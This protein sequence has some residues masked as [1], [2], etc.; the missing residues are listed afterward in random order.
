MRLH[1]FSTLVT[2]SCIMAGLAAP[3]TLATPIE[4]LV[5][6]NTTSINTQNGYIDMQFNPSA[7][8]GGGITTATATVT[9]FVTNGTYNPNPSDT[10]SGTQGNVTV[11]SGFPTTSGSSVSFQNSTTLNEFTEDQKFGTSISFDLTLDGSMI[12]SPK[13]TYQPTTFYLDF[14]NSTQDGYLLTNDPSGNTADG[15]YVGYVTIN[16]NGT[17]TVTTNAGPSNGPSD[18]TFKLLSSSPTGT[19]EPSTLLL[20][21]GGLSGIAIFMRRRGNRQGK[22]ERSN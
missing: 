15:Y 9:N 10:Y 12:E 1:S 2:C 22:A 11:S 20:L 17:T 4:Y 7:L 21:G 14:I 19:P 18:A 13:G 6:V 8:Y 16:P 5:T 3:V